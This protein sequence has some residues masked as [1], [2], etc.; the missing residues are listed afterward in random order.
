MSIKIEA[1]INMGEIMKSNAEI[2]EFNSEFFSKVIKNE[3]V[4]NVIKSGLKKYVP[5]MEAVQSD[6]DKVKLY[7]YEEICNLYCEFY[8]I[9]SKWQNYYS[10]T[11]S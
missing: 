5:I 8:G 4:Q 10:R 3:D 2:L 7:G 1:K 6:V 9:N 11:I